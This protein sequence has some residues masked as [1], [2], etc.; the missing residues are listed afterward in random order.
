MDEYLDMRT[1]VRSIIYNKKESVKA[2]VDYWKQLFFVWFSTSRK[3]DERD[4]APIY[5]SHNLRAGTRNEAFMENMR[6]P[7]PRR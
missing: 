3:A 1:T 6:K 7:Q 4:A 2:S 5:I